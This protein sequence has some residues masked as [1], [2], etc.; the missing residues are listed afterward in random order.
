MS[1]IK[2]IQT[3]SQKHNSGLQRILPFKRTCS[4]APSLLLRDYKEHLL[5]FLLLA[6]QGI[7]GVLSRSLLLL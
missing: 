2:L 7:T 3:F 4:F 6:W 5:S 1:S